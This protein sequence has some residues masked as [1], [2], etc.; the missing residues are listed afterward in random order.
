M[1]ATCPGCN[2]FASL[3]TQEPEID[4]GSEDITDNGDGSVD[5]SVSVTIKRNSACCGE[6]MK[7]YEESVDLSGTHE[8]PVESDPGEPV[9]GDAD[10]RYE[11]TSFSSDITER[12]ESVDKKGKRIPFRYQKTFIGADIAA[13][14][15][16][17]WCKQDFDA[18]GS[19]E[20]QASSFDEV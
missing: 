2:K 18:T 11:V 12:A 9:R 1:A 7:Y 5:I 13:T 19:I 16:C 15:H 14:V 17:N 3:E 4:E 20:A 8:C 6:E 10:D